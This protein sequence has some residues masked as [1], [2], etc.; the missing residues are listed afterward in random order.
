MSQRTTRSR[1]NTNQEGFKS[2]DTRP[3]TFHKGPNKPE[4]IRQIE[5]RLARNAVRAKARQMEADRVA[6][7][8]SEAAAK[9]AAEKKAEAKRLKAEAKKLAKAAVEEVTADA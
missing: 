5:K 1:G 4:F 7:A 2:N 3:Q 9:L 8:Q 6:K